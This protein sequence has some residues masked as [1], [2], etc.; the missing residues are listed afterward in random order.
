MLAGSTLNV[1]TKSPITTNNADVT[2]SGSGATFAAID[3]IATNAGTLNILD[4]ADF[5]TEGNLSNT[6]SLT[7]GAGS[8]LSVK[9]TYSQSA[10]AALGIEVGGPFSSGQFGQIN[11]SG[12]ATLAGANINLTGFGI[13]QGDSF[14]IISFTSGLVLSP[15]SLACM[16]DVR[17]SCRSTRTPAA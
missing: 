14:P 17:R 15:R 8:T 12:T 2:L 5:T 16:P 7:L 9:G 11:A 10:A 6:G 13:H 4:G 1:A 3:G